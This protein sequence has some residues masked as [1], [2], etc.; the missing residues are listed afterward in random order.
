MPMTVSFVKELL[1]QGHDLNTDSLK[2]A[3]Y[4]NAA[5]LTKATTAYSTSNEITGTGYVAGGKT[6]SGV[7]IN[8]DTDDVWLQANSI[9]WGPNASFTFRKAL[10]YNTSK[11]NKAVAYFEFSTDQTVANASYTLTPGNTD[12]TAFIRVRV[13]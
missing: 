3:L 5:T 11:S 9:T 6:L 8:S 13:A 7:T 1:D 12:A 2:V 4:T 10:I